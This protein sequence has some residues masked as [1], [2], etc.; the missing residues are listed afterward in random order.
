MA[1]F[2][3]KQT[4]ALQIVH[5]SMR[6]DGKE[7]VGL[8]STLGGTHDEREVV[9]HFISRILVIVYAPNYYY[10]YYYCLHQV[11]VEIFIHVKENT[12]VSFQ[13]TI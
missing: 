11:I 7:G 9:K 4:T 5:C 12:N 1:V 8:V 3:V 2:V 10:F 13:V 6:A